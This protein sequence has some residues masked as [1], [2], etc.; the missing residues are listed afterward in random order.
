MPRRLL[1]LP[2]QL[3]QLRLDIYNHRLCM[4]CAAVRWLRPGFSIRGPSTMLMRTSVTQH[5][6]TWHHC[7]LYF[8]SQAACRRPANHTNMCCLPGRCPEDTNPLQH[9]PYKFKH[10]RLQY[11][12]ENNRTQLQHPPRSAL[13]CR[14]QYAQPS[15]E[16]IAAQIPK[17]YQDPDRSSAQRLSGTP[18]GNQP[19]HHDC[20]CQRGIH[21]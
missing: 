19:R 8:A 10:C 14:P 20:A 7:C 9:V 17:T 11:E 15:F 4:F 6:T 5:A 1:L 2:A 3:V 18:Q 13:Y 21:P 16:M 12:L